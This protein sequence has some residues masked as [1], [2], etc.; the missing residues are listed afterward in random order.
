MTRALVLLLACATAACATGRYD[1]D[2]H[3][4]LPPAMVPA[5]IAPASGPAQA[6][7]PAPA[8][9]DWWRAFASP[10]LDAL[11][12]E[13]LAHN[14]DVASADAALRQARQLAGVAAGALLPQADLGYQAERTRV[15]NALS[16]A[17]A[18]Q[19]QQLYTLHTAQV[20]V[21][22]AADLF[23][24][25]RSRVRSARAAA[26]VQ[27]HRLAAARTSVVANLV[28]AVVLRA[29]LAD[30]VDAARIGVAINRDI[31]AG[32]YG[33]SSS[34]RSG[35]PTSRRSR[36]RSPPPRPLCRPWY[37]RKR[38]SAS[39]SP[40]CS[41]GRR[42]MPCRHYRRWPPCPCRPGCPR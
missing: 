7:A 32:S 4:P 27:G 28:Q 11:V 30:Q 18:D 40:R 25:T 37:D 35:S 39:S 20:T 17:V 41:A 33:G 10:Q 36:P 14:N 34:A 3:A 19:T 6:F 13:A 16:P 38:T 9:A 29:A 23:G 12:A 42:G 22:Y 31:L 2:A 5:P 1:L 21:T 24:A 8:A 26:A 15:S